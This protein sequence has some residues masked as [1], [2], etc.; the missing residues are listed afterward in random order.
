MTV[1]ANKEGFNFEIAGPSSAPPIIF[2]HPL[3][4]SVSVWRDLVGVLSRRYRCIVFDASGH[5]NTPSRNLPPLI[6]AM[7]ADIDALMQGIVVDRAHIV[8]ASIGGMAAQ[9]LASAFPQRVD[10][11]VLLATTLKMPEPTMWLE[12]AEEVREKG[13][14]DIAAAAMKRWFTPSFAASNPERVQETLRSFLQTD[15]GSYAIACEAIASMDMTEAN[16]MISAPTL[17]MTAADDVSTLP[18]TAEILRR[19]ISGATS[20]IVP[21]AAHLMM[22]ERAVEVAQ[23]IIAFLELPL[24]RGQ[25]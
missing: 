25:G 24:G 18:E 9:A 15:V 1:H 11:L 10:M 3:G 14:A 17:V 16:A 5:G 13:L 23:W 7:A 19:S 21:D 20:I 12:R 4:G 22:I 2:C 6:D 8:G